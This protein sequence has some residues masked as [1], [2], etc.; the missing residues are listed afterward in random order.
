MLEILED[1]LITAMALC[2]LPSLAQLTPNYVC[3][4]EPV[5]PPHEMSSWVNMPVDRIR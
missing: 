3:R 1:E 2:G 5:T 4:A